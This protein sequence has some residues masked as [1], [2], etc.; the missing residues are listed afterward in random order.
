MDV[1][2]MHQNHEEDK[3][4]ESLESTKEWILKQEQ[5]DE[6]L[7]KNI[8]KLEKSLLNHQ[9]KVESDK[10]EQK[11]TLKSLFS[12]MRLNLSEDFK[13]FQTGMLTEI[14]DFRDDVKLKKSENVVRKSESSDT[15]SGTSEHGDEVDS[16]RKVI[17][18]PAIDNGIVLRDNYRCSIEKLERSSAGFREEISA[19]NHAFVFFRD[20]ICHTKNLLFQLETL[21]REQNERIEAMD[22]AHKQEMEAL[23]QELLT[24]INAANKKNEIPKLMEQP[25]QK[26]Q[27]IPKEIAIRFAIVGDW[28][29][30]TSKN[31]TEFYAKNQSHKHEVHSV[32][33]RFRLVD[34][35]LTS[36]FFNGKD[37]QKLKCKYTGSADSAKNHWRIEGNQIKSIDFNGFNKETKVTEKCVR[38]MENGQLVVIN[39]MGG[40]VCTRIYERIK[41]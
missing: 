18:V 23:R 34:N 4:N 29:L 30:V 20:E 41:P 26:P 2:E 17:K 31:L 7:Y 1:V 37:Y 27:K 9:Q 14:R 15:D 10:I 21:K 16:V 6:Y 28:K 3:E 8:K 24:K 5:N 33:M 22:K 25:V 36:Y 39:E 40:V 11:S 12:E 35:K 32:N 13:N 19:I 38:Y